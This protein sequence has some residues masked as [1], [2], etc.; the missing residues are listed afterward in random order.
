MGVSSYKYKSVS[1]DF[2]VFLNTFLIISTVIVFAVLIFISYQSINNEY[3]S[4]AMAD[5]ASVCADISVDY[6]TITESYADDKEEQDRLINLYLTS[7]LIEDKV[8][9]YIVDGNGVICYANDIAYYGEDINELISYTIDNVNAEQGLWQ[10]YREITAKN[11]EIITGMNIGTTG[12]YT[13]VIHKMDMSTFISSYLS[14]IVY[15]TLVSLVAAIALFIGFIGLTIRP[16]RDI[17]RT[18][19]KVSEGDLTVRVDEK[20][21]QL[22]DSTGMLTLSSDLTEMARDVNAMIETLENQENDRSLFISSVAH[23]IRTPLTSIN[24]FVTAMIDGTIPPELFEKYLTK[25]KGEVDKIRSLVVSMTE[26]SSLSHVEP[27]LMDE[28]DIEEAVNEL[29]SELEPQLSAKNIKVETRIN[30]DGG[31]KVYGEIQLLCRVLLNIVT[32]AIKFTP[33]GGRIIISSDSDKH[34]CRYISIE[35]SGPGVEPEKRSRV[36]ES[37]YK[38]DPSRKQE[39]FGLGLYICKQILSG[40]GQN[41]RLEESPELGGAMFIF[42]FPLPPKKD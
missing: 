13:V 27:D 5:T 18:V 41:I 6:L 10:E 31:T 37:F 19:S 28:F 30:K 11:A 23:D 29:L 36:F 7:N 16:L 8:A 39:G 12:M 4:N 1:T 21:T 25:I 24:G 9:A 35:D 42:S 40:H 38:A 2:A 20:Y 22:G 14:I 26:A 32:N 15:P 17:S 3:V 34:E 33:E